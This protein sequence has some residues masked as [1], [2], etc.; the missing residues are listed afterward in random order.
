MRDNGTSQKKHFRR[1]LPAGHKQYSRR[2]VFI[3]TT[4]FLSVR[5][6]S[7]SLS[8]CSWCI[9]CSVRRKLK[10]SLAAC[11]LSE[12]CRYYCVSERVFFL[13]WLACGTQ[14]KGQRLVEPKVHISTLFCKRHPVALLYACVNLLSNDDLLCL[15]IYIRCF[16]QR[17]L[18]R[19]GLVV[20][21]QTKRCIVGRCTNIRTCFAYIIGCKGT[22]TLRSRAVFTSSTRS[23]RRVSSVCL[24]RYLSLSRTYTTGSRVDRVGYFVVSL[25]RTIVSTAVAFVV[26]CAHFC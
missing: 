18:S 2:F 6:V 16:G 13:A 24:F 17:P 12:Q 11:C 26:K 14:P 20:R 15:T 4:R 19:R 25:F 1:V 8:C 22:L 10:K 21:F 23:G 3:F 5:S 7:S 9:L